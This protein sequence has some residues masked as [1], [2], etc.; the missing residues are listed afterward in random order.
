M[1]FFTDWE[2]PWILTDI[3]YELSVSLFEN[4]EF[5]ERLSQ[6]DDYLAYKVKKPG[7]QAGD[8]LKLLAPFLVA[9]GLKLSELKK[10]SKEK[11]VFVD[12]AGK[13]IE[14]LQEKYVPVVVSTSYLE[15]LKTTAGMIGLEG[16]LHGTSFNPD[17]YRIDDRCK[18]WLLG[19]IDEISCLDEID[20][21][22]P[23]RKSV[24][25]LDSLFWNEMR[26][27]PFW[28]VMNDVSVVGSR[29]KREIVEEYGERSVVA[30]GDSIS[31][32]EMFDYA[33]KAGGIAV[34]F[35]GN[36]YA[37]KHASIALISDSA[38]AEAVVIME[39]LEGGIEALMDIAE[40]GHDLLDGVD[41][42]IH[43]EINDDVLRKSIRM[44]RRLRGKAGDLG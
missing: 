6:Y 35:N 32:I 2:G 25:F 31:D 41:W 5:F 43:F 11:A 7:Y 12:D 23:D 24:R 10:I 30:V 33:K 19:K 44:R 21:E 42:E 34:S 15:Y 29:R 13:A 22:N 38:I 36:E 9:G 20:S 16:D 4:P 37:L 3:A 8:T 14:I 18:K 28:S 17:R 1:H 40:S 39:Y 27:T 26:K